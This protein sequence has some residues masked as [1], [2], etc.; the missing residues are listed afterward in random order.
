[1]KIAITQ[2][3]LPGFGGACC[4]ELTHAPLGAAASS[5]IALAVRKISTSMGSIARDD[6][7]SAQRLPR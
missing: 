2:I 5:T 7:Q 3:A 4:Y 1:M 6:V